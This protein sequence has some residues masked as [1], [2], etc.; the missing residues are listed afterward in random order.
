MEFVQPIRERKKIEAM[1]RYLKGKSIR[2]Y[3]LFVLGISSALRV[4][5]IITL[6]LQDIWDGKKVPP[7]I[8]TREQK[9]GKYKNFPI[10]KNLENAIREYV[11]YYKLTDPNSYIFFSRIGENQPITRFRALQVIKEAGEAVGIE[12][13]LGTHSMRKTWGYWAYKSGYDISL[14]CEA[15]GHSSEEITRRYIGITKDAVDEI[16]I[17]LNL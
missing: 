1:K 5:D 11:A 6:K 7:F 15:F 14:L 16:Y 3:L 4:S 8:A 9:R 12:E 17:N 13:N 10:G 2:D